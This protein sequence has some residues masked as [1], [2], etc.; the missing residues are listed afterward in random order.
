MKQNG[1]KS[2]LRNYSL[3]M[4]LRLDLKKIGLRSSDSKLNSMVD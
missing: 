4:K 3:D 1:I 2:K